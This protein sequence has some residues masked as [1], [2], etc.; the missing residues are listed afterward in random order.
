MSTNTQL[1]DAI[2]AVLNNPNE[3]LCH[4]DEGW[5]AVYTDWAEQYR[6][7]YM[8]V[9]DREGLYAM[10]GDAEPADIV[11]GLA[12]YCEDNLQTWL[13]ESLDDELDAPEPDEDRVA[14]LRGLIK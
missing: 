11:E 2:R 7:E 8:I 10:A 12:E 5:I 3:S 9:S 13:R 6:D 14:M 1:T 4:C